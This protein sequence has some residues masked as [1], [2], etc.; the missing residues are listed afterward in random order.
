VTGNSQFKFVKLKKGFRL[1]KF[2]HIEGHTYLQWDASHI[3]ALIRDVSPAHVSFVRPPKAPAATPPASSPPLC[4]SSSCCCCPTYST[5]FFP[6]PVPPFHPC[7]P[8]MQPAQ[9]SSRTEQNGQ[10]RTNVSKCRPHHAHGE[11]RLVLHVPSTS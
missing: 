11:T 7:L 2:W 6:T 10:A 5:P 8:P 1:S 9:K 3:A 4:L